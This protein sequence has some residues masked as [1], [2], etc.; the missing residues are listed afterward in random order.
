M[1]PFQDYKELE[2]KDNNVINLYNNNEPLNILMSGI[3]NKINVKN[4]GLKHETLFNV[5]QKIFSRELIENEGNNINMN[6]YYLKNNLNNINNNFQNLKKQR[7]SI[8]YENFVKRQSTL[9]KI[10]NKLTKKKKKSEQKV[11]KFYIPQNS[12]RKTKSTKSYNNSIKF[13]IDSFNNKDMNKI[14][15]RKTNSSKFICQKS[16]LRNKINNVSQY[17]SSKFISK[18]DF[19][20]FRNNSFHKEE[21]EKDFRNIFKKISLKIKKRSNSVKN[22]LNALYNLKMIYQKEI[23]LNKK[24]R[25]KTDIHSTKIEND[26]KNSLFKNTLL[27]VNEIQN[28]IRDELFGNLSEN[29]LKDKSKTLQ[30]TNTKKTAKI[31]YKIN[32]EYFRVLKRK[33]LVYDSLVDEGENEDNKA[34]LI[35]RFYILPNSIFKNIL[36]FLLFLCIIYDDFIHSFLFAYTNKQVFGISLIELIL[37][38]IVETIYLLDFISGFFLA[39]YNK[40]ENLITNIHLL[41]NNYYKTYLIHDFLQAIPFETIFIFIYRKNSLYY[42]SYNSVYNKYMY[43]TIIRKFKFI[44]FISE[45]FNNSLINNLRE[46]EHFYFY[47]S[48]YKS[49]LVFFILLHNVTCYYILLGKTEFPNWIYNL[50]LGND[51]FG[52]IYVCALYYIISTLTTVGYGDISTCTCNERIFGI[53]ILIFGILGYSYSL[54]NVSNYV[55]KMN[56]KSEEYEEKKKF[57]DSLQKGT[58][59]NFDVYQKILKHLKYQETHRLD[60]NIILDSL[61]LGLRNTLLL[62]IYKPITKKFTFFKNISNQ[63]FIIQI[64]LNFKPIL[65]LKNDILIKDGNFVEEVFFVKNGKLSLEVP[66]NINNKDSE[67]IYDLFQDINAFHGI[68]KK[69]NND[70]I[71]KIK[72]DNE[73]NCNYINVL[74]IREY[75]HYGMIERYLNERSF[76]RVKVKTKKAELLFLDKSDIDNLA[77]SYPQIWKK[78]NK[79]SLLNY[80]RMKKLIQ[81]SI[82]LHY[83]SN[84]IK[85]EE[86]NSNN[87]DEEKEEEEEEIESVEENEIESNIKESFNSNIIEENDEEDEISDKEKNSK[88]NLMVKAFNKTIKSRKSNFSKNQNSGHG[89]LEFLTKNRTSIKPNDLKKLVKNF[90]KD[91]I[92]K[93]NISLLPVFK[94]KKK[95]DQKLSQSLVDKYENSYFKENNSNENNMEPNFESNG[96]KIKITQFDHISSESLDSHFEESYEEKEKKKN[97]EVKKLNTYYASNKS[98]KFSFKK[99]SENNLTPFKQN[100]INNEIYPSEQNIFPINLKKNHIEYKNKNFVNNLIQNNINIKNKNNNFEIYKNDN[101]I[102]PNSYE[103][104]NKICNNKY[105]KDFKTQNEIKKLL[106]NKY[107]NTNTN[108]IEKKLQIKKSLNI[109]NSFDLDKREKKSNNEKNFNFTMVKSDLNKSNYNNKSYF[110]E[111]TFIEKRKNELNYDAFSMESNQKLNNI[112]TNDD[113]PPKKNNLFLKTTFNN[114]K[115]NS[116]LNVFNIS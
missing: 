6:N 56:S 37:N 106:E 29:E 98:L 59:L 91:N 107:Q 25:F 116:L 111:K 50:N 84:G 71:E 80:Y 42:I 51:E 54:T 30:E 34:L 12:I 55:Q 99:E 48:V 92:N 66:T 26:Y 110:N 44:K 74:M 57:L 79:K 41:I 112:N 46:F 32:P 40:D 38:L 24:K 53:I 20:E 75:E 8:A 68:E 100:E 49:I 35:G 28:N 78:I 97:T 108:N 16:S 15:K 70:L 9:L 104:I 43:F 88:N 63:N 64:L 109:N 11:S 67:V 96:Y 69:S 22:S 60:K 85:F 82:K 101:F 39:Y 7:Y 23:L 36:D 102:I 33:N 89:L 115:N 47:E 21:K 13:N 18:K 5:K 61:P 62:E 10:E 58:K 76:V 3:I 52:K 31:T 65:A 2:S 14:K 103:N 90:E 105:I 73:N 19:G 113:D 17:K 77:E 114:N 1:I 72:N 94:K 87:N 86:S 45:D 4:A 81:K 93:N 83:L 95:K 27:E